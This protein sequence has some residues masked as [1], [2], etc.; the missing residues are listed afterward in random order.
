[1]S[2][3]D[4]NGGCLDIFFSDVS[5]LP[6][7]SHSLSKRQIDAELTIISRVVTP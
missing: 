5:S 7:L 2:S 1:M 4:A 6:I 3:V